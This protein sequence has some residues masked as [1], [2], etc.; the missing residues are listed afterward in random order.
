[1]RFHLI[2]KPTDKEEKVAEWTEFTNLLIGL[3]AILNPLGAIPIFLGLTEGR[4][5]S[6]RNRAALVTG[7]SVAIILV[8]SYVAGEAILKLFGIDIASFRIAG[9]LLILIMGFGM[10]AGGSHGKSSD[11]GGSGTQGSVGVVPMALPVL[12][13]P[14][15][16]SATIVYASKHDTVSS[17]LV[18][19]AVIVVSAVII[20]GLLRGAPKIADKLGSAGMGVVSRVMGLILAAMGIKFITLGL[21]TLFPGLTFGG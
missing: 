7:V 21:G 4:A 8:V 11:D 5:V 20:W 2:K 15:A 9:G 19:G 13:G 16:I 1:M 10:I 18:S 12:A 6:E 17:G 3:L 14:G